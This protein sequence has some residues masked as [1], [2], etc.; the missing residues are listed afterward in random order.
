MNP[1]ALAAWSAAALVVALGTTNPWYRGL[2]ALAAA[3]LLARHALPGARLR[4]LSM[5]VLAAVGGTTL[6]NP[7]V[8][9]VGDDVLF[10]LPPG[11]PVLGGPVTLEGAVFGAVAGLGIAAA[12]LAV[13]P[14]SLAVESH[15]LVNALPN[16]LSRTGAAVSASLN[17]VPGI[18][19]GYTA[20]RE[21]Q[22]MRGWRP[23]GPL[24]WGEVLVPTLLTALEDSVQLAEAMEARAYGSGPRTSF[25]KP[26]WSTRDTLVVAGS[27]A[28]AAAFL[29]GRALG[30]AADWHAYPSLT[31]PQLDLPLLAACLL[32]FLPVALAPRWR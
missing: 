6:L 27:V 31:V 10:T 2:V 11:L 12:V 9:H 17:L 15:D 22:L 19:R 4:P 24:S 5:L 13:A 29:V 21:A 7:L 28:S 16:L 32:L 23:G 30:A 8:G 25:A 14:L 20:I 26:A 18:A 3:A 1:R